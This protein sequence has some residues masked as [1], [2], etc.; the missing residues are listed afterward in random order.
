VASATIL[1]PYYLMTC[2]ASPNAIPVEQC[3]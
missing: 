2:H 3:Y 1:G